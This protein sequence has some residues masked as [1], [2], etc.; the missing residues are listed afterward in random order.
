MNQFSERYKDFSNTDLI[1]IIQNRFTYQP[2]AIIFAWMIKG[3]K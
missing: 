1:R 3:L 2:E